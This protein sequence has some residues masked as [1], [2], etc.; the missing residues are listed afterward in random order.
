MHKFNTHFPE[1]ATLESLTNDR[2]A[3]LSKLFGR[4]G[5]ESYVEPPL[6]VDYGSNISIGERFYANF[7]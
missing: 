3:V 6:S 1:D 5:K 2:E 7:K 4:C